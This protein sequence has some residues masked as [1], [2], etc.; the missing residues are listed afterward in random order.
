M[1]THRPHENNVLYFKLRLRPK[2]LKRYLEIL[3]LRHK[4]DPRMH[5]PAMGKSTR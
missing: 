2:D 3:A 5:K 1:N 4:V